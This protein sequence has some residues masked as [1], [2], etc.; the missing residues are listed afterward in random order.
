MNLRRVL[1]ACA[2]L[3]LF[4]GL[5]SAQVVIPTP[6]NCSVTAAQPTL[7]SQ[8]VTER[9]GDVIITCTGGPTPTSGNAVDRT[10]LSFSFAG[11]PITNPTHADG[12][13][14][15]AAG[16]NSTD[17]LLLIDEPNDGGGPVAGYGQ[18]AGITVCTAVNEAAGGCNAFA[19]Q[20]NGYWVLDTS[21]TP[22][23]PAGHAANAYQG[24]TPS[25]SGGNTVLTFQNVP[26]LSTG[27]SAVERVY[28]LVN[29]RLNVGSNASI[30][31]SVTV[32][33]NASAATTLNLTN[34]AVADG[35]AASGLTTSITSVGGA[36]LCQS[37]VLTGPVAG[38]AKANVALL[39]FTAGFNGAF[40]TQTLA[41]GPLGTVPATAAAAVNTAVSQDAANG[42]YTTSTYAPTPTSISL[43][44]TGSE[45]GVVV[46]GLP[47]G[48]VAG[49]ASSGTRL[50]ATFTGLNANATYWVSAV[51]VIDYAD[52]V[53]APVT[54][55]DANPTPYAVWAGSAAPETAVFG[56]ALPGGTTNANANLPLTPG[57]PAVKLVPSGSGGAEAY[58]EVTNVSGAP[59][60]TFAFYAVYSNVTTPP[61][62]G[63]DGSVSLG[64]APTS[65]SS[66]STTNTWVPRFTAAAAAVPAFVVVPCQTALLFP[67]VSATRVN[68]TQHWDTGI[69]IANTGADPW[70]SSIAS[71]ATQ[72]CNLTFYGPSAPPATTIGPIAPGA[73]Y[74]FDVSDPLFTGTAPNVGFSGYMFAVCNFQ[75][76]HG[77]AYI[78]DGAADSSGVGNSMG[79]L[80]LVVDNTSPLQRA[81]ALT[82]E[83]LSH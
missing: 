83:N 43:T 14:I 31:A 82:G 74:A 35:T 42:T 36:T 63:T 48:L 46:P 40:K 54:I 27:S 16:Q 7:R 41:L 33:P 47:G 80:A 22:N 75:F 73:T 19:Q 77:F 65:G 76:A 70:N 9:P 62:V 23:T 50:K 30:T 2:V 45:S 15:S 52:A 64:F 69:A 8:G 6:I 34:N 51:N 11:V 58:W 71:A 81:A 79:Y 60:L 3:A 5:A 57:V 38:Q 66:G 17:A 56:F 21:N 72:T 39:N 4:V 12:V 49:L 78:E 29:T 61:P 28:R 53:V 13:T 1:T 32:T 55:G 44:A 67:F 24:V 25:A 68:A 59:T 20:I 26:V 37:T 10:T 18:N